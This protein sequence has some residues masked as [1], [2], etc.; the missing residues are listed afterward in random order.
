MPHFNTRGEFAAICDHFDAR[1]PFG[2]R[3]R[4]MALTEKTP[5]T[6]VA[7][8]LVEIAD[9][10][11]GNAGEMAVDHIRN[12]ADQARAEA[13]AGARTPQPGSDTTRRDT[14]LD[15]LQALNGN[16][17]SLTKRECVDIVRG[18]FEAAEKEMVARAI[19]PTEDV[20][21]DGAAYTIPAPVAAEILRLEIE[22]M[23]EQAAHGALAP[24]LPE[25]VATGGRMAGRYSREYDAYVEQTTAMGWPVK[26]FNE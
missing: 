15:V 18:L 11:A 22:L 23:V 4:A 19:A 24:R 12:L 3:R 16:P 26:D 25:K 13:K 7:D 9:V 8:T 14:L 6:V 20:L 10:L 1:L 5:L 21:I 17:Y 2:L